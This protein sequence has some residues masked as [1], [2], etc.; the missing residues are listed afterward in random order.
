MEFDHAFSVGRPI[1]EVWAALGDPEK[2]ISCI[3]NTQLTGPAG[4]DSFE[5][6]VEADVGF[7]TLRTTVRVTISERDDAAHREVLG[8]VAR[9]DDGDQLAD[10]TAAIV[11]TEAAGRTLAAVHTSV[12]VSGIARLVSEDKIDEVANRTFTT[13]GVNLEALLRQ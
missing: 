5:A 10:A 4:D 9:D 13:F 11:A 6:Q 8:I 12:E 3:P 7:V 1:D 2:V